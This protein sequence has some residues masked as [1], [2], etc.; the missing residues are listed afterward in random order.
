MKPLLV[1]A[2]IWAAMTANAF[3]EAYVE[4]ANPWDRRKLG[5]KIKLSSTFCFPAYHFFLFGVMWPLLLALPLV[6]YGWDTKLFGIMLSAYTTG[7]VL[8]DYL[9]FVVNPAVKLSQFNPEWADY[10]PWSKFGK[11]QIPTAYIYEVII[12]ILSWFFLWR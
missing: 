3:W 6:I 1:F 5:W 8:E 11:F 10:Y 7:L 2:V 9:W 4:G 12:A